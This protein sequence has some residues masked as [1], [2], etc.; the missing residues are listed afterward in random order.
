MKVSLKLK[1][2]VLIASLSGELDHHSAKKVKDIVEDAIKN[3]GATSL[4]FDFSGLS[5]MDSSGIGVVVGRYKLISSLG[6]KVSICGASPSVN[7]ILTVSG[8]KKIIPVYE[9]AE[10]ALTN[11][12]EGIC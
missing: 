8:I 10:K 6:G 9:D 7:R 1:N 12:L 5:F 3:K 2:N 4:I 11:L